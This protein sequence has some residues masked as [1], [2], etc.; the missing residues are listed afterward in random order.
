MIPE[1]GI[2]EENTKEGLINSFDVIPANTLKGIKAGIQQ[3]TELKALD[4]GSPLRY[5]RNDELIRASLKS[6]PVLPGFV[7]PGPLPIRAPRP[8]GEREKSC[9]HYLCGQIGKRA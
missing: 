3:P 4:S 9:A 7:H 5:A 1:K 6:G 2:T 8:R